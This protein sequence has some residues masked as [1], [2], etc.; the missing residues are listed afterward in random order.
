M[1]WSGCV[2]LLLMRLHGDGSGEG[3][4]GG[5]AWLGLGLHAGGGVGAAG[6]RAQT[7]VEG[8]PACGA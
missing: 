3:R 6:C 7:G 1:G 4:A 2:E 8:R 5:R